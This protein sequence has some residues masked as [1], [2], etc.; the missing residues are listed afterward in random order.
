MKIP[1]DARAIARRAFELCLVNER[2]NEDSLRKV[3]AKVAETKPRNY[4]AILHDLMRLTRIELEKRE[5]LV[6]SAEELD[7]GSKDRVQDN[8]R[9]QYG[10]DLN[11]QFKQNSD[12]VGGMRIRVGNDVWD[13]SVKARLEKLKSS[14]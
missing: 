8:L 2:L 1:R 12:L 9:E 13:G 4:Q 3:V 7:G 6:E 14:F 10:P 11:F 5:V